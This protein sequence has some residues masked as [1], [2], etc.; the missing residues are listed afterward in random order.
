L[1]RRWVSFATAVAWCVAGATVWAVLSPATLRAFPGWSDQMVELYA[2]WGQGLAPALVAMGVSVAS[3]SALAFAA[4]LVILVAAVRAKDE[5]TILAYCI[6]AALVASPLIWQHYYAVL[7]VP[8]VALAPRLR[9][10][11]FVPYLAGLVFLWPEVPSQ[12][13]ACS[14]G[15]LVATALV[16]RAVVSRMHDVRGEGASTIGRDANAA[17]DSHRVA[18]V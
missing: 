6:A 10:L 12:F 14:V 8:I 17:A 7:F 11:W 9:L 13:V 2:R 4:G 16:T 1:T 15:A 18:P 3:A 5:L